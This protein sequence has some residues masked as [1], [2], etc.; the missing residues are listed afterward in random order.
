V[1][2]K[3]PLDGTIDIFPTTSD[4]FVEESS[5]NRRHLKPLASTSFE[6]PS[7]GRA[8][9]IPPRPISPL[10]SPTMAPH[11]FVKRDDGLLIPPGLI[12]L[13]IMI[14][15]IFVTCM[16]YAV[17]KTFGFGTDGN[18]FKP[19]SVAQ[20]D[21]MAEVRVRNMEHLEQEGRRAWAGRSQRR[22]GEVVYD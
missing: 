2:K 11:H 19:M 12:V 4:H 10:P 5:K 1:E 21:Y 22:E 16:A 9:Q 17:H 18:G 3:H 8:V 15:A 6:T 7:I 14:A 20:M 13:L